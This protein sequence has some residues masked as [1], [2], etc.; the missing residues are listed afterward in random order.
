MQLKAVRIM[1]RGFLSS[2]LKHEADFLFKCQSVPGAKLTL[3]HDYTWASAKDGL[4]G[5]YPPTLKILF[6]NPVYTLKFPF[7]SHTSLSSAFP[8]TQ[9]PTELL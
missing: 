3:L 7:L 6:F 9:P 1:Q 2:P 8:H 4:V 5:Y